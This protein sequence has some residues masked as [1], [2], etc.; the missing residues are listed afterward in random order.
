MQ[1]KDITFSKGQLKVVINVFSDI[2]KALFVGSV[3]ASA[4]S[5]SITVFKSFVAVLAGLFFLS[6]AVIMEKERERL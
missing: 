4:V 5:T 1:L 3:A 2:S 6:V